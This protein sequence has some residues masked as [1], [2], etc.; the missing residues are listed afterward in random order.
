M[1]HP[2]LKVFKPSII[3]K[4]VENPVYNFY[5]I[6]YIDQEDQREK[7]KGCVIE[8]SDDD[9]MD[10]VNIYFKQVIDIYLIEPN[11]KLL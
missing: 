11:I 4:V 9:Y 8:N 6:A 7:I 3:K 5:R 10:Q 1:A 2:E